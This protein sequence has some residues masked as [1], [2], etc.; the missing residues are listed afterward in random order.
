MRIIP[1]FIAGGVI[2]LTASCQPTGLSSGSSAGDASR[3][4]GFKAQYDVA[5]GA[6]EAGRYARA[7]RSYDDLV[8]S[9]GPLAPRVRLE[10]AHALLR[11]DRFADAAREARSLATAQTGDARAAALA[12]QGTAEHELALAQMTREGRSSAV[13]ARM[14]TARAA[15]DEMLKTAPALDP[16]GAMKARRDALRRELLLF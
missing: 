15:L 2:F 1:A 10:Y 12:V 9:A 14:T 3:R 11:A 7:V 8:K 13:R 5:R 4:S 16:A 6:L